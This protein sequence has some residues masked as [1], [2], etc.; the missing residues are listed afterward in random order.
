MRI[1][2][3]LAALAPLT[4]LAGCDRKIPDTPPSQAPGS[5]EL[6]EHKDSD[7]RQNAEG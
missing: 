7:V 3:L 1:L 5:S 2:L 6:L 4:L